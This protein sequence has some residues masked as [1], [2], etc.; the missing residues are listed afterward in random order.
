MF[1]IFELYSNI[2]V[3]LLFKNARITSFS[4]RDEIRFKIFSSHLNI[5]YQREYTSALIS[6]F[7]SKK[8]I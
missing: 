3:S 2:L 6:R 4:K 8:E 5:V 1:E 7:S